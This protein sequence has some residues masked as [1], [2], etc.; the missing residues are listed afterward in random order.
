MVNA[1]APEKEAGQAALILAWCR[2]IRHILTPIA[3]VG[4]A[5]FGYRLQQAWARYSGKSPHSCS[6]SRN[7]YSGLRHVGRTERR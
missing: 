5:A 3:W 7:D 4:V 1:N 2:G 6:A